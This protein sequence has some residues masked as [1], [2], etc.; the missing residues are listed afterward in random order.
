MK[1]Q[2][3]LCCGFLAGAL[4]L[5]VEA[6]AADFSVSPSTD[7]GGVISVKTGNVLTFQATPGDPSD[8]WDLDGDGLPDKTGAAVDWSYRMPAPAVAV[9]LSA[10]DGVT[11]KTIQVLGPSADFV[12]FPAAPVIGQPVQ[13]IY[14]QRE[15]VG[16]IEWDLN[17]DQEFGDALGPVAATTFPQAGTYA[18]SLRVSNIDTPPARSTSTQL[19]TVV[20]PVPGIH[21]GSIVKPR[22]MTP[23]PVIRIIGKVLRKGARIKRLTVRAP[24]GSTVSVRCRGHS[25]PFRRSNR[26]VTSTGSA[27]APSKTIR[28]RRLEHRLLRDGASIK[29][30]VSRSGEIG[31]Y[32]RFRIR[33]GKPPVRSDLCLMP[34]STVPKE[35]PSS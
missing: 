13:F 2:I 29:V 33:G 10:P 35:C 27:K 17:G 5:P 7:L 12:S 23:F 24:Y 1:R 31:K 4:L 21:T 22:L 15:D 11:T 30:L 14:S 19:I 9:T 28:V 25:C 26:K 34:G 18:V 3:L 32:T 16:A 6:S 20:P 8:T